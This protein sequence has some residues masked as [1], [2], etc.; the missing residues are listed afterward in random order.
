MTGKLVSQV[1]KLIQTSNIVL[2]QEVWLVLLITLP[3]TALCFSTLGAGSHL[4]IAD[5][6][7]CDQ[8]QM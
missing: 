7:I 1:K 5:R 2:L 3:L 8:D 4:H 6:T